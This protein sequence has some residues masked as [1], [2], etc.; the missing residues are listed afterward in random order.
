MAFGSDTTSERAGTSMAL[1]QA[2]VSGKS[3]EV[4]VLL[5]KGSL[6]PEGEG[7]LWRTSPLFLAAE[8]GLSVIAGLLLVGGA[9]IDRC[10]GPLQAT[11]LHVASE[12][13]HAE[14]VWRLLTDGADPGKPNRDGQTPLHSA[15]FSGGARVTA[16]LVDAGAEMTPRSFFGD[17]PLSLAIA[18]GHCEVAKILLGAGADPNTAGMND[19]SPLQEAVTR[20]RLDLVEELLFAGA[21]PSSQHPETGETPLFIA[22]GKGFADVV[23]ALLRA[24]ASPNVRTAE[25]RT[26]FDAAVKNGHDEIMGLLVRASAGTVN[27]AAEPTPGIHTSNP[28]LRRSQSVVS[29]STTKESDDD[30][31]DDPVEQRIREVLAADISFAAVQW[32]G[33]RRR[34]LQEGEKDDF[35][36]RDYNRKVRFD[37]PPT[38]SPW[39]EVSTYEP[40]D[41]GAVESQFSTGPAQRNNNVAGRISARKGER[42]STNH[43]SRKPTTEKSDVK[44]AQ[45][46]NGSAVK[47]TRALGKPPV[48]K[49]RCSGK[50]NANIEGA[51]TSVVMLKDAGSVDSAFVHRTPAL[52]PVNHP[53]QRVQ[54]NFVDSP[55]NEM[56]QS[57]LSEDTKEETTSEEGAVVHENELFG[58]HSET[59]EGIEYFTGKLRVLEQELEALGHKKK[60]AMVK[61]KKGLRQ[62]QSTTG[63]GDNAAGP[64]LIEAKNTSKGL[65]TGVR[66]NYLKGRRSGHRGPSPPSEIL[67]WW[68]SRG[69]LTKRVHSRSRQPPDQKL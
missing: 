26:P 9:K 37:V 17:T 28:S 24:E 59:G 4:A 19:A 51:P 8:A 39:Y 6:N 13:G 38:P 15:T 52:N 43:Q 32:S 1:R 29:D 33:P 5:A 54:P 57:R 3:D 23:Q 49:K 62:K 14:V 63:E 67:M 41:D 42:R 58:E 25:G 60:R 69:G 56:N 47:E 53:E 65:Q 55:I 45:V 34:N 16:M 48:H 46:R 36:T 44:N 20:G 22:A 66:V 12:C 27:K 30:E 50:D 11:A 31:I 7:P 2:V 64:D 18:R 35:G 40:E 68:R 21:H 10:S 61:S